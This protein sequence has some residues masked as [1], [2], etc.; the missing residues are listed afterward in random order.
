MSSG[1]EEYEA[2]KGEVEEAIARYWRELLRLER[3]GRNDNFFALGGNSLLGTN[4][5]EILDTNWSIQLPV[6][7]LF[8]NPTIREMA[9]LIAPEFLRLT[10]QPGSH[11]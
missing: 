9:E 1:N 7:T 2:P 11:H 8:Q 10:L 6:V 4:L 5:M 3:V